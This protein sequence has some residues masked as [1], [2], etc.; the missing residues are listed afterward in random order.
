MPR[1]WAHLARNLRHPALAEAREF[2]EEIAGPYLDA[3]A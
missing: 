2:V 1:E 3:A